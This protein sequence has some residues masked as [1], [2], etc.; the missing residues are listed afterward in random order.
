MPRFIAMLRGI[1]VSGQKLIKM[2]DL[3]DSMS[4]LGF[5]NVSTYVQSGNILFESG[6]KNM[7]LLG[8]SIEK[9][10][11]QDF[12]FDVACIVKTAIYFKNILESNDFI[13][14][15]KDEKRCY[16]TFL[17][18]EPDQGLVGEID[19]KKYLPEEFIL[20]HDIIYFY[21]PEGYGKAKMNNNFFEQ[22]LKV[23][24]TTR[25]WNTVNKL[26]EMANQ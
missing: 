1:N 22:R 13:R 23:K 16:V 14:Q 2:A 21:S 17:E 4:D 6:D 12:G 8:E 11:K 9:Q 5:T 7:W 18:K 3:R 26:Y 20:K 10:I 25:N 19:Q 15:G 24:A